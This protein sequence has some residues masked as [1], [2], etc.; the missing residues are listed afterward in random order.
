[1]PDVFWF[2]LPGLHPVSD[3]HGSNS[4]TTI[5]AKQLLIESLI[6]MND[7]FRQTYNGNVLVSVITTDASH[8]RLG[9]SLKA[10]V[11]TETVGEK[12]TSS[13]SELF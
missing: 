10:D 1:M 8:T 5:E 2:I 9:R 7:A 4:S 13:V 11:R 3:L 12:E 6:R